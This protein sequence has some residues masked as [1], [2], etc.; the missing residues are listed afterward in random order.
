MRS[1][2]VLRRKMLQSVWPFGPPLVFI[3]GQESKKGHPERRPKIYAE[4]VSEI[5]AQIVEK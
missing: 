4:E 5:D 2:S 1:G 3:F